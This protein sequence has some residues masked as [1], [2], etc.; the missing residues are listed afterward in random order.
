MRVGRPT[1]LAVI[2]LLTLGIG[3]QSAQALPVIPVRALYLVPS[4]RTANPDYE[5]AIEMALLDL[6]SWY[7][8]Q[9]GG[10]TFTL[11]SPSVEV[12]STTHSA[13]YYS[14]APNP[15]P[16]TNYDFFFNVLD[17]ANSLGAQVNDPANR[18]AIYID[19]DPGPGQQ[20]GAALGA[21]T[22]IGAPDLRGLIGQEPAPVS[23]W[24]GGL[25]HELGHTFGLPH[26]ADCVTTQCVYGTLNYSSDV[27][28]GA[29]MQFG[30]L[31]YPDTYLLPEEKAFLL[32]TPYFG[33]V[34]ATPGT[35]PEP[36]TLGLLLLG[37]VAVSIDR[38]SKRSPK[39]QAQS[40]GRPRFDARA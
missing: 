25:G 39:R 10:S 8:D 37:T 24:I 32:S 20:G 11:R 31:T 21:L 13:A 4:D 26:P 40:R 1:C 23:R 6:Q 35:V 28:G 9:L 34:D 14:T 17:D 30:Y 27:V 3:A 5:A 12:V 38:S 16:D 33:P 22:I 36:A 15:F 19:A 7:A 29:L 18:W 2:F